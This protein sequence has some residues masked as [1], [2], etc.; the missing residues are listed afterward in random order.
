MQ[1]SQKNIFS[2]ANMSLDAIAA[3]QKT[4]SVGLFLALPQAKHSKCKFM[5]NCLG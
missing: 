2:R 3:V 1:E 4:T 5:L